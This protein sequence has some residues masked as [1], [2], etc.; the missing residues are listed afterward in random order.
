MSPEHDN[1]GA[2]P[3]SVVEALLAAE[4]T[5][6][7]EAAV[8]LFADDAIVN[9]AV[10][11]HHGKAEIRGWQQ[12]LADGHFRMEMAG[13]PESSGDRVMFANR[14]DLDM[15]LQMGLGTVDALSEAVVRN[16]KIVSYRFALAPTSQARLQAA[17]ERSKGPQH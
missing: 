8:A 13:T 11:V 15:F 4:N 3:L 7:V 5:H 16:G 6:D 2:S 1:R 12:A 17:I 9:L 14:L 10:E